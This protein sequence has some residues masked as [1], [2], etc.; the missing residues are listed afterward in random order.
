M[1][2]NSLLIAILFF[3][4]L[5]TFQAQNALIFSPTGPS[6]RQGITGKF[7]S[8]STTVADISSLYG[9]LIQ[10]DPILKISVDG[11]QLEFMLYENTLLSKDYFVT[12]ATN[13]KTKILKDFSVRTYDGV[14]KG[15]SG[16]ITIT[17]DHDY[18]VAMMKLGGEEYFIEQATS[19]DRNATSGELILYNSKDVI[20][21]ETKTC[22]SDDLINAAPDAD[23]I[24]ERF[25]NLCRV[26]EIA[27]ASDASMFDK[28]SSSVTAVQNHNI[29]VMNNVAF[30]YLHEFS[31]N[32]AFQIVTQYVS[33]TFNND[34]LSPNTISTAINTVYDAFA[35]WSLAG[36]FGVVHDLGTFWTN[37]DFDGSTIGLAGVA[38][39]CTGNRFSVLQDFTPD[40]AG[41]RSL[42][43]HEVGHNFGAGHDTIGAPFIMAPSVNGSNKWSALSVTNINAHLLTR[44]CLA[45]CTGPISAS[46]IANPT[47][48]CNNGTVQFEDK[49]TNSNARTWTFTSGSPSTST[50]QKPN[51]T[52]SS[53]GTFSATI[54]ANGTSTYSLTN[55]VIVSPP[56]PLATGSCP[57]PTGT[58][59]SGGIQGVSLADMYSA[60]GTAAAD[61]NRYVDRSCTNIASLQA[62]TSYVI[63]IGLGN[64][65]MPLYESVRMYIDYNNN[66][67]FAV[68]EEIALDPNA[69]VCGFYPF[70]FST[71]PT[72][73]KNALLRMRIISNN[74]T[75]GITGPCYNPSD[76]QVEDFSVIF[77]AAVPLPLDLI[78]FTGKYNKGYND[79][80]W[81]TKNESKI[82]HFTL[83]RSRDGKD[84][85]PIG[86][87][88]PLNNSL[89]GN[90]TFKD[91]DLKGSNGWYYRLRMEDVSAA[92]AYSQV[93]FLNNKGV[94][95]SMENLVT[96]N[97]SDRPISFRLTSSSN[98]M[99]TI[100]LFDMM[101]K[102]QSNY[103]T[104]INEGQNN[105]E[106]NT[107]N[108]LKG[109]YILLVKNNIGEELVN[110][111]FIE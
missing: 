19:F 25:V 52:Y 29:A 110:K 75:I 63:N 51:V 38:A 55:A 103:T 12:V 1:Q 44:A 5:T 40:A 105:M 27:I 3:L 23:R 96:V 6:V 77:K 104:Q 109:M 26:V 62:N 34:P 57:L 15:S 64:C 54:V 93:I 90:Y 56:P 11:Q 67:V 33:T 41:L 31:D 111:I 100:E 102:L 66:G 2:S 42:M 94:N 10:D 60:S 89:G 106:F 73:V 17:I 98:Q 30:N 13:D 107:D 69:A 8:S 71:P 49:S 48:L 4:N 37:R 83:E 36:G 39:M 108:I 32:I 81:A 20:H 18:F 95:L 88:T 91:D 21:D 47:A 7:R 35:T 9:A 74:Y 43:A 82:K 68:S 58:P 22:A 101:G 14:L 45:N 53:T 59:G 86:Y 85:I 84:F 70:S 76:G 61:G 97:T 99:V 87:V 50:A 16:H 79:L 28:Y 65:S 72:P 24:E 80:N 92:F 46:F 78:S